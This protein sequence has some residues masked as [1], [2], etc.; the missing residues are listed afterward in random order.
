MKCL[1]LYSVIALCLFYPFFA[2]GNAASDN[3]DIMDALWN[4]AEHGEARKVID[5]EAQ[6]AKVVHHFTK[7]LEKFDDKGL[8]DIKRVKPEAQ[9]DLIALK[10][11]IQQLLGEYYE[12]VR[13]ILLN[14]L[15]L[16]RKDNG[17]KANRV[18]LS[19]L[20]FPTKYN[21]KTHRPI[22]GIF[23]H[24]QNIS[25]SIFSSNMVDAGILVN[26]PELKHASWVQEAMKMDKELITIWRMHR[27]YIDGVKFERKQ[28][29]KSEVKVKA[30]TQK[31]MSSVVVPAPKPLQSN[32]GLK[33]SVDTTSEQIET[34]TNSL[35]AYKRERI[36]R[37]FIRSLEGLDDNKP[38]P[39]FREDLTQ[40]L[41]TFESI[42][43]PILV[44]NVNLQRVDIGA[45]A[46][47]GDL[48]SLFHEHKRNYYTG[49]PVMGKLKHNGGSAQ[50]L[51]YLLV[52]PELE[53]DDIV[54]AALL[55]EEDLA[56]LLK[57]HKSYL[58]E[59][60]SLMW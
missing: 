35:S 4:E 24:K 34:T 6:R 3:A 40:L 27:S 43:K 28:T 47:K 57:E 11:N 19:R 41:E 25:D 22:V 48:I 20:M 58:K 2:Q 42:V 33:N 10:Q 38:F 7:Q 26:Y 39:E 36:I 55:M 32:D 60:N 45:R 1:Q 29:I 16:K 37:K 14:N 51:G 21:Y 54:K 13:P 49:K 56:Q 31:V 30:E 8:G 15:K 23:K 44:D 9:E 17:V 59:D 18:D 52:Q 50:G 46:N 53:Q 5:D 12:A